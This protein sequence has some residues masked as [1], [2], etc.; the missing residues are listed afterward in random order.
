MYLLLV[1]LER[2]CADSDARPGDDFGFASVVFAFFVVAIGA[3][4]TELYAWEGAGAEFEGG[5]DEDAHL[6]RW[7]VLDEVVSR[8][9]ELVAD[10][11]WL[12]LTQVEL[13]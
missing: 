11:R 9:V 5:A 10:S 6:D 7:S 3:A 1:L 4:R 12:G 8:R 13:A 2:T